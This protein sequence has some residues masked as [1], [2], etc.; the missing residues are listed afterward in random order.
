MSAANSPNTLP[1]CAVGTRDVEL[2]CPAADDD[3]ASPLIESRTPTVGRADAAGVATVIEIVSVVVVVLVDAVAV[4]AVVVVIVLV[5]VAVV[6]RTPEIAVS[7]PVRRSTMPLEEF[8]P[9]SI[10]L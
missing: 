3:D 2:C 8:W 5:M 7:P 6:D 4:V 10:R 1:T 9:W